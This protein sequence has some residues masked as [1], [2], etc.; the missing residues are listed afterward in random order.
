MPRITVGGTM[1][2]SVNFT[3]QCFFTSKK[4]AISAALPL[5]TTRLTSRSWLY[6]SLR[7]KSIMHQVN[8]FQHNCRA[9]HGWS[10]A[11]FGSVYF[12]RPLPG[13]FLTAE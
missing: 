4:M 7:K 2:M 1:Q 12:S 8:K 13:I 3:A 6:S 5:E 11:M 10:T 9:M